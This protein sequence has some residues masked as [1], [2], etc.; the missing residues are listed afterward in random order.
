MV[1]HPAPAPCP[2]NGPARLPLA[3][4]AALGAAAA[5]AT[6]ARAFD[7]AQVNAFCLAGFNAAMEAARRT[8]PPGM[9]SFTCNCF[10]Q[11]LAQ[12]ESINEARTACRD[13]ASK[14]FKLP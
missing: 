6:P 12:G 14:Q 9:A 2:A 13:L 10:S 5:V 7:A 3:V 4:A 11:R 1:P 8:P